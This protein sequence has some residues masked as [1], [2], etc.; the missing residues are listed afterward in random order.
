MLIYAFPA[1]LPVCARYVQQNR[2]ACFAR[3]CRQRNRGTS[4][5]LNALRKGQERRICRNGWRSWKK[6]EAAPPPLQAKLSKSPTVLHKDLNKYKVQ[7]WPLI[8]EL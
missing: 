1:C 8:G 2:N 3:P 5:K 7:E 6:R 4:G